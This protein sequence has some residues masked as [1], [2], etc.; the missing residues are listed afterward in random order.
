MNGPG[1]RLV[2]LAE[3]AITTKVKRAENGQT[4]LS[5]LRMISLRIGTEQAPAT[6]RLLSRRACSSTVFGI[7]M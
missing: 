3:L 2:D 7:V 4:T 1:S 6:A 5:D